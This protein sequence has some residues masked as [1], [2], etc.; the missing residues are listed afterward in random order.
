MSQSST[1]TSLIATPF[2]LTRVTELI[3]QEIT[4]IQGDILD[5]DLLAQTFTAHEFFA[6]MHF[7]G[8]KAVGES[9]A[10][11]MMYYQNNVVGTINLLEAMQQANVKNLVFS[12]SATVYGDPKSC[13][14]SK[15]RH[16]Q[17]PTLMAKPNS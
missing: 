16:V 17:Q 2:A 7:A 9:V 10:K 13:L 8:L 12:S 1:I 3:G 11:P 15:H 5:K 14:L 6:V 4:F